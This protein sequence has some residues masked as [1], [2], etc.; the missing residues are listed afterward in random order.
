MVDGRVDL[1]VLGDQPLAQHPELQAVEQRVHLVPVPR[2]ADQVVDRDVQGQVADQLVD[3]P[4]PD[5]VGEVL[6]QRLAG[7]AL[8]LV[9]PVDHVVQRAELVQPLGRGLRP[10]PGHAGQVV[11]LLPHQR[12]EIRIAAAAV[13]PYLL[14]DRRR[15]HPGD[16][17]HATL[18]V[19][20]RDVVA[21]QLERVPVTAADQ[22]LEALLGAC[23]ASVAMTSSASQPS[24]LGGRDPERLQ[25]LLDQRT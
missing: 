10:D 4:V 7:L 18:R 9:D 13:T 5:H 22:H 25:H 19:Q 23:V 24:L 21:D 11:A 14:L 3:L 15:V 2:R 12:R 16:L 8:D 17:G 6:A 1:L 20:H